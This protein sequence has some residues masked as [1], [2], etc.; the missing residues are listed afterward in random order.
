[1]QDDGG[2]GERDPNEEP[3]E[4]EEIILVPA[5][6]TNKNAL[7]RRLRDIQPLGKANFK[8]VNTV[9]QQFQKQVRQQYKKNSHFVHFNKSAGGVWEVEDQC[10]RVLANNEHVQTF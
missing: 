1:M 8:V 10:S 2:T 7:I 4:L 3:K 9:R 6:D 5:T